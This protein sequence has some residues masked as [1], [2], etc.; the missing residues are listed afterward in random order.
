MDFSPLV[1]PIRF[2]ILIDVCRHLGTDIDDLVTR[3]FPHGASSASALCRWT[4]TKYV[5]NTSNRT[6]SGSTL[7]IQPPVAMLAGFKEPVGA[8]YTRP[9]K[10]VTLANSVPG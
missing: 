3:L 5:P 9:R 7:A 6:Y 10:W 8:R 2:A 1:M 4:Y